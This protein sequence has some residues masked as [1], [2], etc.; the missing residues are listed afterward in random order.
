M[1]SNY[2]FKTLSPEDFERL[3]R[4]LLS[5]AW[6]VHLE[7]FKSGRDKGVD[8]RYACPATKEKTIVQ[9][10]HY[11]PN[12]LPRLI[13]L[14]EKDELPKVKK[15]SPTRYVLVTSIPLS[16]NDKD[17]LLK[18]LQPWCKSTSDII[19]AGEINSLLTLHPNI[20][21][22]HFKL[23]LSSTE[24]LE[25]VLH[26]GVWN[27]SA[28]TIDELKREICRFVVHDGF[29]DALD[30]LHTHHHCLIVGI[31]GIGKTTLA[32]ILLWYYIH[33]G[34]TA[35]VVSQDISEA[36][37]VLTKAIEQRERIVVLYD[38]FLGQVNFESQKL[39]KNEDQR[40]IKMLDL[41]K[42]HPNLRFILTTRE[43][44][45]ADARRQYATLARAD[46]NIEKFTL[47][48]Q[49]YTKA[50]RARI[51]FNHLYFSD[52]PQSRLDAVVKSGVY[53]K[54]IEHQNYNPRIIR[55]I[56]EHSTFSS[57]DDATYVKRIAQQF[58]DPSE[59]WNHA[60]LHDIHPNS[61]TLLYVLWS[62]GQEATL[63][64]LR[65]AF[66]LLDNH[67]TAS[68]PGESFDRS[69]RELDGNFISTQRFAILGGGNKQEI[70]VRF[71]NPS[72][73]DYIK[74]YINE[75]LEILPWLIPSSVRFTQIET[76]FEIFRKTYT[77]L[78]TTIC[79]E[80]A[81]RLWISGTKLIDSP[82]EQV[83]LFSGDKMISTRT[84]ERIRRLETIL[85]IGKF[86]GD[87]ES[88]KLFIWP[89]ITSNNSWRALETYKK[90]NDSASFLKRV[91][92]M[93]LLTKS[94]QATCVTAFRGHLINVADDADWLTTLSNIAMEMEQCPEWFSTGDK[95]WLAD[96]TC[97]VARQVLD[98]LSDYPLPLDELE[99]EMRGFRNCARVF[100]FDDPY[101]LEEFKSAISDAAQALPDE[102][103]I[104]ER[105]PSQ[106]I[107]EEIDI[108]GVFLELLN[109]S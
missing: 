72:I 50:N 25:R 46:L 92:K 59:V 52:L 61:R 93:R 73:R 27:I 36:W 14:L 40:L 29:Q 22:A 70:I 18:L 60:F 38:D 87:K 101:L 1:S 48:L 62:F 77:T 15:L 19:G 104:D 100:K 8:L 35:V 34:F 28:A 43:Y 37:S 13:R 105:V 31:P 89:H 23:W 80:I 90:F 57:L 75:H 63:S 44:I 30:I 12:A 16:V 21:R 55:G 98:S 26:A 4:D 66:S 74:H 91:I 94:E 53:Q 20:L 107:E 3:S 103:D 83:V 49:R 47:S 108:K 45:L 71:H 5:A 58:D 42:L 64:A 9:C 88:V 39:E 68:V 95:E 7:S 85:N 102:E 33:E 106:R 56:C 11:A 82:N 86:M 97:T 81:N 99:E 84:L 78:S 67:S 41:V 10:K 17:I 79:N 2:D 69:M 54:I 65:A 51:L 24:I 6:G 32:Q 76:F 109:R 96:R